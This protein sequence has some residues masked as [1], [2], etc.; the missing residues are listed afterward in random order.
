MTKQCR[1][2]DTFGPNDWLVVY[3]TILNVYPREVLGSWTTYKLSISIKINNVWL[4]NQHIIISSKYKIYAL[5]LLIGNS[6]FSTFLHIK[7]AWFPPWGRSTLPSD[8]DHFAA[9]AAED[10]LLQI[11]LGTWADVSCG[12]GN[13]WI[14]KKAGK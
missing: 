6:W 14:Q 1:I 13:K 2:P 4:K 9:K 8:P 7:S 11:G 12:L 5:N 10:A 3:D